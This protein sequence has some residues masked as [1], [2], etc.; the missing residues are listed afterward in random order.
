[1]EKHPKTFIKPNIPTNL[2]KGS[3]GP[4]ST[5]R[6]IYLIHHLYNYSDKE[7]L[8]LNNFFDSNLKKHLE[9]INTLGK[10]E[11]VLIDIGSG[12]G[13]VLVD[14]LDQPNL[15]KESRQFLTKNPNIKITAIGL[16]DSPNALE[17][18]KEKHIIRKFSNPLDE[19]DLLI[20]K[21]IKIKN[22]F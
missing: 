2:Y 15:T 20:N 22:Y 19:I 7:G 5:E 8:V 11:L 4:N 16:T 18:G 21:R 17:Q 6:G 14:L 3:E 10:D 1:L 9:R 13:M 12:E